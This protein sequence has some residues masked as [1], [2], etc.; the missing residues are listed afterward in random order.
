MSNLLY[1]PETYLKNKKKWRPLSHWLLCCHPKTQPPRWAPPPLM[2]HVA[3]WVQTCP[4]FFSHK[5]SILSLF[6]DVLDCAL[7]P[8]PFKHCNRTFSRH[9]FHLKNTKEEEGIVGWGQSETTISEEGES[10]EKWRRGEVEVFLTLNE[11]RCGWT[12]QRCKFLASARECWLLTSR[13][14][15][16]CIIWDLISSWNRFIC[17]GV[18]QKALISLLICFSSLNGAFWR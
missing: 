6:E 8:W 18:F 17:R 15:E 9:P 3:A 7:S 16:L 4:I 13:L 10:C 14:R 2:A 12:R 11:L 5:F 1:F